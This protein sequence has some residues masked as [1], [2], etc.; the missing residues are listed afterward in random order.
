MRASAMQKTA[1]DVAGLHAFAHSAAMHENMRGP[2]SPRD[3]MPMV[4]RGMA[5]FGDEGTTESFDW[6]GLITAATPLLSTT[7]GALTGQSTYATQGTVVSGPGGSTGQQIT[8]PYNP[9][10]VPGAVPVAPGDDNTILYVGI[11]AV[12]LAAL[13]LL[14][15]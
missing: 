9:G 4:Q 2:L 1:R 14:K 5:G 13:F 12:A 11:G 3:F 15:K 6:A 10:Y 8:Q 7:V